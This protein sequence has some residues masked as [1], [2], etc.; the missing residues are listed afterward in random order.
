MARH[1]MDEEG[2]TMMSDRVLAN[3]SHSNDFTIRILGSLAEL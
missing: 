1:F 2:P 3:S